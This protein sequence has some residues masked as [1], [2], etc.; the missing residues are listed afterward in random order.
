M[1]KQSKVLAVVAARGGS[2]GI[3]DKN[4]QKINGKPLVLYCIE[5]LINSHCIDMI[6]VSTDSQKIKKVVKKKFPKIYINDRPKKYAGDKIPLTSVPHY[7]CKKFNRV[8][9]FYDYVLQ[10]A[11][12]C[13]KTR[14]YYLA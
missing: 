8:G 14:G 1:K 10:V 3:K 7:I 11:P 4:I 9:N 5:A 2:K 13:P 6:C 12:T